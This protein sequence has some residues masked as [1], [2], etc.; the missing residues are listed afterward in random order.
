MKRK[1]GDA[2][3]PRVQR[4]IE[5][6]GAPRKKKRQR[7]RRI[8]RLALVPDVDEDPDDVLP[9]S[10]VVRSLEDELNAAA[11]AEEELARA[12]AARSEAES[13]PSSPDLVVEILDRPILS[14]VSVAP[15]CSPTEPRVEPSEQD[16]QA[17]KSTGDINGMH[18]PTLH[19]PKKPYLAKNGT[20]DVE[21]VAVMNKPAKLA[22]TIPTKP[23]R[24]ITTRSK[25]VL[26]AI[27]TYVPPITRSSSRIRSIAA[28]PMP[29]KLAKTMSSVT[30]PTIT[31]S[32]RK[33]DAR[34]TTMSLRSKIPSKALASPTRTASPTQS[35]KSVLTES[36]LS[37]G[38]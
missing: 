23:P 10:I 15:A 29:A 16:V 6:P 26:P 34:G 33:K 11:A 35:I 19:S 31:K 30:P 14:P 37:T 13:A 4:D 27:D 17:E 7:V 2:S 3:P 18:S 9:L 28:A 36:P 8:P 21:K 1:A 5:C 22:P 32:T 12:Q 25:R 24:T 38:G 20:K